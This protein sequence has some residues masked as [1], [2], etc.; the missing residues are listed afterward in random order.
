MTFVHVVLVLPAVLFVLALPMGARLYKRYRR[1][2]IVACPVT[3][4]N[5]LLRIGPPPPGAH[6]HPVVGCSEWPRHHR[7]GERCAHEFHDDEPLVRLTRRA[8]T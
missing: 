2:H 8:H 6:R 7:C 5:A 4:G 1:M 3:Q